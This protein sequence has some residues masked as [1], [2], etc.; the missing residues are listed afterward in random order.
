M[1]SKLS[2]IFALAALFL[3]GCSSVQTR[4]DTGTVHGR[5]FSFVKLT[6]KNAPEMDA[7]RQALHAAIQ[8][9]I[10]KNLATKGLTL[11]PS[12]G[13]LTV[14]YLVI[15]GNNAVTRTIDDYFGF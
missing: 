3:A 12:G 8:G 9:A 5:T 11:A 14:T 15:L 1:N 13:D 7:N 2:S 6:D 4:V 10:T